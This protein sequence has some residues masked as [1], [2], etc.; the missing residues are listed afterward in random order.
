MQFEK[1][2]GPIILTD[3]PIVIDERS[4]QSAKAAPPI[5]VHWSGMIRSP[6]SPEQP[7]KAYSPIKEQWSGIMRLPDNPVH[8]LKASDLIYDKH[9]GKT[10]PVKPVQCVKQ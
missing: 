8:P 2:D 1:A 5:L 6:E 7:L 9:E 4:T 10:T 3:S